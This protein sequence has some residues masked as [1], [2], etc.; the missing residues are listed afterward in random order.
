MEHLTALIETLKTDPALLEKLQRLLEN[1]DTDGIREILK[2]HDLTPAQIS[3]LVHDPLP[4][5]DELSDKDLEV[6]SGGFNW[7]NGIKNLIDSF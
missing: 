5:S 1:A 3:D 6:V 7:C 2:Q 4:E